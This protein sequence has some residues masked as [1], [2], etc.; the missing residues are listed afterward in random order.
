MLAQEPRH[1]LRVA[2]LWSV[3]HFSRLHRNDT[4]LG[5]PK[6]GAISVFHA[7]DSASVPRFHAKPSRF[8]HT[9]LADTV[10]RFDSSSRLDTTAVLVSSEFRALLVFQSLQILAIHRTA[11]HPTCLTRRY[12]ERVAACTSPAEQARVPATTRR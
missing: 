3:R 4:W 1:F 2:E 12:S 6:S 7:F 5:L 11:I 9:A 8:F 10:W